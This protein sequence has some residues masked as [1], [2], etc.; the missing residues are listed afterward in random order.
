M[1]AAPTPAYGSIIPLKYTGTAASDGSMFQRDFS[2]E[3]GS[4]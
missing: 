2:G 3:I 1:T 4:E